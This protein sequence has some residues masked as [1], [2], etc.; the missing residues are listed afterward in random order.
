MSIRY[1]KHIIASRMHALDKVYCDQVE[2]N[3]VKSQVV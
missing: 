3:V 1:A 2:K